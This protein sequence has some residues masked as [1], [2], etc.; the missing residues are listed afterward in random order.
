MITSNY[1]FNSNTPIQPE[2]ER[3][4]EVFCWTK[5]GTEAGQPIEKILLRKEL[6]RGAGNGVFSWGIGNSL[7]NTVE[8]ALKQYKKIDVLF[9]PM[10]SPAKNKDV[11]P[12][13]LLLWLDYFDNE[14][15]QVNLPSHMLITSRG[16]QGKI[17]GK[18]SH[19]ALFCKSNDDITRQSS[20]EPIDAKKARNFA[21]SNPLGASQV[22]ALVRYD[23]FRADAVEQPYSVKF[24]AD[25][26]GAGFIR[27]ASPITIT[28][29]LK[30]L[31]AELCDVSTVEQWIAGIKLL[32]QRAEEMR[33]RNAK[34]MKIFEIISPSRGPVEQP[35]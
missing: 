2:A 30:L 24:R 32:R 17:D 3:I 29:E 1:S 28:G 6:E 11:S 4:P 26:S 27:L 34:Q 10:K 31:Y 14:H 8:L 23:N 9:S 12:N 21:S 18:R 15:G 25:L 7:G 5:M 16:D 22:T 33:V 20:L 13:Q 35:P 19:Y